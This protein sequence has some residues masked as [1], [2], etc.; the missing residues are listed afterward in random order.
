VRFIGQIQIRRIAN[1]PKFWLYIRLGLIVSNLISVFVF[2]PLTVSSSPP[3][4]ATGLVAD[5]AITTLLVVAVVVGLTK[6][7]SSS[8]RL[9][10]PTWQSNPLDLEHPANF[11]HAFGVVAV[12]AGISRVALTILY[13]PQFLLDSLM[14][15][16]LGVA[17]LLGIRL[18]A[19]LKR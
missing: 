8:E 5:F 9:E 18:S 12:A 2:G 6:R 4:T 1:Q 19:I 16:V 15:P 3:Q 11:F 14:L 13:A 7:R 10:L 17:M